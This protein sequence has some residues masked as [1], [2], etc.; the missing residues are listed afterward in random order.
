MNMNDSNGVAFLDIGYTN[1]SEDLKTC[2]G[3]ESYGKQ[4]IL[5]TIDNYIELLNKA[6][7]V[8]TIL[9]DSISMEESKNINLFSEGDDLGIIGSQEL[10]DRF[11]GFGI[12]NYPEEWSGD[13]ESSDEYSE[14]ETDSDES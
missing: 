3:N 6:I 10:V 2:V 1:V 14:S 11:V 4:N 9:K 8:L 5:N 7:N 12:A 13:D